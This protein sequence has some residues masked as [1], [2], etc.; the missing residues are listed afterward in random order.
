MR[1][2]AR[3]RRMGAVLG[4]GVAALLALVTACSSTTSTSSSSSAAAQSSG[5]AS[6]ATG[7]PL[8]VMVINDNSAL[9]PLPDATAAANGLAAQINAAG[10]I[11]GHPI[12]VS[13]CS[14]EA[15]PNMTTQC[16]Q[17]AASGDYVATVGSWIS[18]DDGASQL[19]A[20]AGLAQLGT[21]PNTQGSYACSTCFPVVGGALTSVA[22]QV[23][24]GPDVLHATKIGM[25]IVDVPQGRVLPGLVSAILAQRGGGAKLTKISYV[26]TTTTDF[27]PF[28]AQMLNAGV[29]SIDIALPRLMAVSFVRAVA[30]QGGTIPM[31]NAMSS[32]TLTDIA[33]L[34]AAADHLYLSTEYNQSGPAYQQFISIEKEAG[35]DIP[36][37]GDNAATPFV[38][39]KIFQAI[40]DSINGPITRQ[41]V[42]AA[43][44]TFKWNGGGMTGPV[45]FATYNSKV[46]P[47]F[48]RLIPDTYYTK[49]ANG[50]VQLE[51]GGAVESIA[52]AAAN[53]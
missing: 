1:C 42:L 33:N 51:C 43:A 36:L 18:A 7:S 28:A 5:T 53:C 48:P 45:D 19:M 13:F 25:V 21:Y 26:P 38:G 30:A 35:G 3:R 23:T 4:A 49:A 50:G 31:L 12:Q 24:M 27:S 44:K 41:S 9:E 16:A 39:I 22:G 17:K 2:L 6:A 8:K 34:G 15:N 14:G 37:G 10:G 52:K 20:N 40:A 47:G 11:K 32:M 29:Q 46:L